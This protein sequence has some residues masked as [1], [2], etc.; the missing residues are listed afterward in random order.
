MPEID[1]LL[2]ALAVAPFKCLTLISVTFL[3]NEL[4][5]SSDLASF[6]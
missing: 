2:S 3:N 1:V 4:I 6:Y 5:L